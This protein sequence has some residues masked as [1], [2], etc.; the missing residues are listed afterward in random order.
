MSTSGSERIRILST[1]EVGIGVVAPTNALEVNGTII[2]TA[3]TADLTNS[4][5]TLGF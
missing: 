3:L 2:A 1:G 4:S 5:N